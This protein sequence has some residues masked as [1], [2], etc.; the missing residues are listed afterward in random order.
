MHTQGRK[1]AGVTPSTHP[2]LHAALSLGQLVEPQEVRR[3]TFYVVGVV[4]DKVSVPNH[5][6]IHWQ[7]ADVISLVIILQ[8]KK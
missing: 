1:A 7:V 8:E 5:G 4:D 3:L 2:T 6:E